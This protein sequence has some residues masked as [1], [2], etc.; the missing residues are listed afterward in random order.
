VAAYGLQDA[1]CD[2]VEANLALGLPADA[3]DYWVAAQILTDLGVRRVRLLSNNPAK[4][5]GLEGYG[6]M[7]SRTVPL[8]TDP[9][10]ENLRYLLAK[11]DRLGHV[12][13]DLLAR[14]D[15]PAVPRVEGTA[16]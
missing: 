2:T 12:L 13:P 6:V 15:D 7:V 3:R 10:G 8:R 1:G 11:R 4:R 5:A 14:G 9:T 16:G